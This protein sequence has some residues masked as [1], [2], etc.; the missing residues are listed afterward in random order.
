MTTSPATAVPETGSS[1]VHPV[2]ARL[3]VHRLA[4]YGLQH[5]LVMYASTVTVPVVVAAGLGLSQSDLIYLVTV[6]LLLC[7]VGTL[8]QSVGVWKIG[9]R[10]PM[11]IGASYTG[12]APM[13]VIGQGSD[14]QTMYGAVLVVGLATIVMAPLVSRTM[15]LFPPVV[16]G[17]GIL[18][19]GIQLIPAGGK[20]IVGTDPRNPDFGNPA[21]LLLALG[22]AAAIALCYRLLPA[23]LRPVSVLIG[24]IVGVIAAAATGSIDLSAV[25][26]GSWMSLPDLLHFGAPRFDLV[27]CLSLAVIQMVLVVELVGQVKAVGAVVGKDVPESA[28]A[29]AVRADGVVTALGGGVFQSFMYVTFAQNVG[30]LSITKVVSRWVTATTGL[31][32]LVLSLFPFMGQIVSSI[33]RP[34]LGAAAVIMFGTIAVVG[35]RILAAVDFTVTSNLVITASSLGVAL[36]PATIPGFYSAVPTAVQQILG[37]GVAVGILVAVLLN[38]LFHHLPTRNSG[39][40]S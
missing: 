19:I 12:I 27:A 10:M 2:D 17:T 24:M 18:L 9:V 34:V 20:M 38:L 11:V 3:P 4:V 26:S 13:L 32:L 28:L 40:K 31:M 15:R 37:S 14:I 35:I 39:D 22:T 5:L 30:I 1:A 6:D 21:H 33:P 29:S 25:G 7:G 8:L 23:G 16:I 36:L